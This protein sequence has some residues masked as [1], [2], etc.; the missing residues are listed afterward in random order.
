[1]LKRERQEFIIHQLHLHNKV[2]STDLSV[3]MQ[4]SEDTIRRDL[5]ELAEAGRIIKVHG[6]AISRSFR[7]S[8]QNSEIYSLE[9]KKVI[10][11]KALT[12]LRDGM[13]FFST[14]GTTITELARSI[15]DSVQATVIT[16]SLPAAFEYI[17]HPQLDVIFIGDRVSRSA[18]LTVGPDAIARIAQFNADLCFLGTNALS[19]TKGLTDNDLEVAQVK[20]ALI[21]N[22]ARVVALTISEKINTVQ[23][24]QVC[25]L[26]AIHTIITELPPEDPLL[27]PYRDAGIEVL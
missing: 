5:L 23:K 21:A 22:A 6:G 4:V 10:A 13:F 1:M 15:P 26:H 18:Q 16:G 20:Q 24:I 27:R 25:P 8:L 19:D 3:K 14:G 2:L 9:K 11:Q 12:L 7:P 17:R